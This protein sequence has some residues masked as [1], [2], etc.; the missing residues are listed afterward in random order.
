MA[1]DDVSV[2]WGTRNKP[3]EK[4]CVWQAGVAL[5]LPQG[6]GH[7]ELWEDCNINGLH[8]HLYLVFY[9]E[10]YVIDTWKLV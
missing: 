10:L 8:V 4:S 6:H 9:K 3:I 5:V 1:L 2:Y 7:D